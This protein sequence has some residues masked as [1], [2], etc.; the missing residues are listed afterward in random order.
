M[1]QLRTVGLVPWVATAASDRLASYPSTEAYEELIKLRDGG[2]NLYGVDSDYSRRLSLE[3]HFTPRSE[4]YDVES[5]VRE[6]EEEEEVWNV[7]DT[8]EEQE[9]GDGDDDESDDESDE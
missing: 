5:E 9:D 7:W 8:D 1:A 2:I 6:E 3:N 4:D